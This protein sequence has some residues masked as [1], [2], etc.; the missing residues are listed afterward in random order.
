M[1]GHPA[2]KLK[3]GELL[4]KLQ[5]RS[6]RFSTDWIETTASNPGKILAMVGEEGDPAT[7]PDMVLGTG[8]LDVCMFLLDAL[9]I[10]IQFRLRE[11]AKMLA[12]YLFSNLCRLEE[13]EDRL[14]AQWVTKYFPDL[15]AHSPPQWEYTLHLGNT[16]LES[17]NVW[18]AFVLIPK[19]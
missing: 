14:A 18:P 8:D 17:V 7:H 11:E 19:R 15:K 6:S 2:F 5:A 4:K 12:Q 3:K 9:V 10:L 1:E 16:H 13:E